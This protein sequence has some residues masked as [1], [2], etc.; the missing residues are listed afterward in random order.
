VKLFTPLAAGALELPNRL[1]MAPMT[2]LRADENGVP[3]RLIAEHY[4]QRASLGLIVSEGVFPSAESKAYAGQPG[5]VT[6]EQQEGWREVADS[7]H[8]AGGRI[9]MQLMNGGRVTSTRVTGTERIVA[10]SAIAIDG[11]TR[12]PDGEKVPYGLPHELTADELPAVREEF[13]AGARRAVD[14][15]FDGV[16]IHSAN[17][18]LLHEFLSPASNTRTDAYGGSPEARASFVVEVAQA[19]AAAVGADRV[20][21][22]ISPSHNIQDVLETDADDVRATYGALIDGIAPLGLAY[23]SILHAD[24]AGD[25]VQELRRRF[26]GV[27]VLNSGFGEVTTRE[28]ALALVEDDVADAVAVGRPAIANPDLAERWRGGHDE[29]QPDQATI[30]ASGAEGYTDYPRL[31]A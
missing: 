7:V 11:E 16:E 9:V 15:G 5:I 20:G 4:A 31:S 1:V 23:L 13:V 25:L 28:Q 10:P 8:S 2:R 22:R 27:V 24:P 18:Y 29:N 19:V 6:A 12:L 17:G 26:S 30:Y 21:I 3:G 14:A